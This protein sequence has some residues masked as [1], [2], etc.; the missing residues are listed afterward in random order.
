MIKLSN[1][2]PS[3]IIALPNKKLL[4]AMN[5]L[6]GFIIFLVMGLQHTSIGFH[7]DD[8]GM[9]YNGKYNSI[10]DVIRVVK[11]GDCI[12]ASNE[13]LDE[14]HTPRLSFLEVIYRPLLVLV[15]GTHYKFFGLKPYKFHLIHT[16]LHT[17][18]SLII[19]N[20]LAIL[21]HP[22]SGLVAA[23]FFGLHT[24][25]KEYFFW[26]C[27]VQNSLQGLLFLIVLTL[28]CWWLARRPMHKQLFILANIMLFFG[29]CLR[30]TLVIFPAIPIIA[31]LLFSKEK[32]QQRLNEC[33]FAGSLFS[34]P[35]ISYLALR[36]WAYPLTTQIASLGIFS[37]TKTTVSFKD[38]FFDLLTCFFD[39]I[40]LK[41]LPNGST[42]SLCLKLTIIALLISGIVLLW[43][44]NP[45]KGLLVL[46]SFSILI[47]CWPS[48]FVH[49]SRYIYLPVILLALLIGLLVKPLFMANTAK[50]WKWLFL[51][52]GLVY[53]FLQGVITNKA[54]SKWVHYSA[55]ETVGIEADVKSIHAGISPIHSSSKIVPNVGYR[56]ALKLYGIKDSL[57]HTRT[58]K[59]LSMPHH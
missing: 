16:A 3:T 39:L 24:S 54:L 17:I 28:L 13:P 38:K 56:S 33:F 23:L 29:L 1:L 14:K 11:N 43:R 55:L 41:W 57:A 8:Y 40:G 42:L 47:L 46:L 31:I 19:F 5:I 20:T 59:C 26:Q 45:Y 15:M 51:S 36:L 52:C 53:V 58:T 32:W 21:V 9:M 49:C 50:Q 6:V 48:F 37:V 7:D 30:E 44:N 4:L 25:L 34:I 18:N 10:G 27:Y 2:F 12:L 35:V 22:W